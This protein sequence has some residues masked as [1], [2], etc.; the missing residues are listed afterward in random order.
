MVDL[1]RFLELR[2]QYHSLLNRYNFMYDEFAE[3][4]IELDRLRKERDQAWMKKK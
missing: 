3:M 1:N 2:D 4:R